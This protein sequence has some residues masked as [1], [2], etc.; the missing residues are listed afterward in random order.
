MIISYAASA[1][2]SLESEAGVQSVDVG[3]DADQLSGVLLAPC[4][5]FAVG[6]TSD[7]VSG[8]SGIGSHFL[9]ALQVVLAIALIKALS[10]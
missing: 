8:V 1:Q 5:T 2:V 3:G 7:H 10:D 6:S 9:T 4:H